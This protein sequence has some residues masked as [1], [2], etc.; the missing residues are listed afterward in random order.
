MSE[1]AELVNYL[2]QS[3]GIPLQVTTVATTNNTQFWITT[4]LGSFVM[5]YFL[6]GLFAPKIEMFTSKMILRSLKKAAKRNMV[7]IK[8]TSSGFLS[9]NMIDQSTL[10]DINKAMV[11]FEGKD[12]DLVLHT[13]GG[14][15]FSATFIAR[16]L[17][18]YPGKIRAVIPMYAMSGGTI[19][20]LACNEIHMGATS[21]LGPV[22]PQIGSLFKFGSANA[23][24]EVVKKKGNK[25]EDSS[26]TFDLISQ[27]YTKSIRNQLSELVGDKLSGENKERFL[28]FMTSG[29]VEHAY[30]IS[31]EVLSSFGFD[32]KPINNVDS[33][34]LFKVLKHIKEGVTYV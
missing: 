24:R 14:E 15:I 3:G 21:C 7:V 18:K 29:E 20:T 9:A 28:K 13:P 34:K 4:L 32:I 23:W 30:Q 17:K 1:I 2:N 22:D 10:T 25:A 19:L 27:Q 33:Q 6:W 12:F 26:I 31:P 11:K 5:I 16:L 8:H